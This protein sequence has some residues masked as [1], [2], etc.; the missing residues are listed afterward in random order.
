MRYV[1]SL[2][3]RLHRELMHGFTWRVA[4]SVHQCMAFGRS[5]SLANKLPKCL[6][7]ALS[8]PSSNACR[9]I[10]FAFSLSCGMPSPDMYNS[11]IIVNADAFFFFMCFFKSLMPSRCSVM[12]WARLVKSK[13]HFQNGLTYRTST[14]W[15][16]MFLVETHGPSCCKNATITLQ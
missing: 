14:E 10:S 2:R 12:G 8:S 11:P 13:G 3:P 6:H 1:I 16:T 9:N 7:A 5:S 4:A 15:T